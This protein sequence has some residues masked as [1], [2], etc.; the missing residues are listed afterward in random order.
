[1]PPFIMHK[2]PTN[3]ELVKHQNKIPTYLYYAGT[4]GLIKYMRCGVLDLIPLSQAGKVVIGKRLATG[5]L[6]GEWVIE[7]KSV[8][9][10]WLNTPLWKHMELDALMDLG[11]EYHWPFMKL[12]NQPAL[13]KIRTKSVGNEVYSQPL[14]LP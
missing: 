2:L 7:N 4:G 9:A 5:A 8:D 6:K 10:I 11:N 12:Q 1:M 3:N 14:P 13:G